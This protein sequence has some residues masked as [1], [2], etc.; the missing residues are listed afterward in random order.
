M[1][2]KSLSRYMA[3]IGRKGGLKRKLTT[4]QAKQMARASAIARAAKAKESK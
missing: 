2:P 4:E 1:T 3:K